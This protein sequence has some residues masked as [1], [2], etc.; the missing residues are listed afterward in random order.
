M[1]FPPGVSLKDLMP[2]SYRHLPHLTL[3]L[4]LILLAVVQPARAEDSAVKSFHTITPPAVPAG[5]WS[6]QRITVARAEKAPV[7]D[8]AVDEPCWNKATRAVGFYRFAGSSP[9][10]EQTEAWIAADDHNLYV[11]F[12]CQDSH[13]ELIRASETQRGGDLYGD[14]HVTINID[15]QNTRRSVSSFM[16]SANG[17]QSEEIEGGTAGNITWAGDWNAATKRTDDG[18]TVEVAIPFRLL[19]Y[20]RGTKSFGILLERSLARETNPE[21]W[22]FIPPEGQSWDKRL[23]YL[24]DFTGIAPPFFAPKPTFLPYILTT[25]GENSATKAG[26]DIKYPL[27]TTLTGVASLF[28]D[29]RTVEQAVSSINFSYNELFVPDRRP[30]FA[31]GADYLPGPDL[32][33]SRRIEAVDGG[34]KAVGKNGQ[35]T[36][37]TLG[38]TSREPG[39]E[40]N[41][42]ALNLAQDIGLLSRIG[43]N[44]VTDNERGTEANRVGRLYGTYGW[45]QAAL[46]YSFSGYH[47]RSYVDAAPTGTMDNV[48]FRVR[49][50]PG[51]PNLRMSYDSVGPDFTSNLGLVPET[52]KRGVSASV[53][54]WNNFDKGVIETY[55]IDTGVARYH[56]FD[57]R[58]FRDQASAG[59]YVQNRKGLGI[60]L[61]YLDAHRQEEV[62]DPRLHDHFY[63]SGLWW[64]QKSLF[65]NGGVTYSAGQQ[66][67]QP[68]DFVHMRQGFLIAKPVSLNAEFSRQKLG[69]E[70]TTQAIV[71]G[72]YRLDALRAFSGRL[73]QQGGTGS[74][75]DDP[76]A[77]PKGTNLYLAFSQR[78]PHGSDIYLLLGDPNSPKTKGEVTLK[79]LRPY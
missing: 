38:I 34:I 55:E 11:A 68:Y 44:L 30:F 51:G 36:I 49:A 17:T 4:S 53:F 70:T 37:G 7:I 22:P 24:N 25:T 33:Y 73:I 21:C 63:E 76:N 32:F 71:T 45:Q 18:W 6:R 2:V 59:F 66:D 40:R 19:R 5:A 47:T 41:S 50:L 69:S 16:V 52:D 23:Q 42:I 39:K 3:L 14:D 56:R 67:G 62:T 35:T 46:Q 27:S 48:T 64:N 13:P 10:S 78:V 26:M 20:P 28:P 58:F 29:F 72:T 65:Q 31:E 15:S 1:A 54:Q 43:L 9:V 61:N 79:I 12:H 60:S 77:I 8:G 57:G 75:S 74:N